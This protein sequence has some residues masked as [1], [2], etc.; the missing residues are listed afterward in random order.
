[1]E[2]IKGYKIYFDKIIGKGSFSCVYLGESIY[3]GTNVAI[4]KITRTQRNSQ[5]INKQIKIINLLISNPHPNVVKYYKV[6]ELG[7]DIY[8]IMEYYPCGDLSNLLKG[9]MKEKYVKYYFSQIICGLKHISINNICHKDIK[10][11]NI[12]IAEDRQ[13]LKISDFGLADMDNSIVMPRCGS[14]MYMSPELL[15]GNNKHDSIVWSLGIILYQLLYGTHP[16]EYCSSID[17]LK[18]EVKKKIKIPPFNNKNMD[19]SNNCL[20]L[21]DKLLKQNPLDRISWESLLTHKWL[22]TTQTIEPDVK[23]EPEPNVHN[24][25]QFDLEF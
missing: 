22:K 4:K 18:E 21:L 23:H 1:M 14:P 25:L 11:M 10:P 17:T 9:P 16:Y 3:N 15:N 8:I 5:R 19:V 7:S 24:D 20:D 12:L 2:I 6:V 13:V